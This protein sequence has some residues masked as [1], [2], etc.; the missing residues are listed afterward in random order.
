VLAEKLSLWEARLN[1]HYRTLCMASLLGHEATVTGMPVIGGCR[2]VCT[3]DGREDI[4]FDETNERK[5]IRCLR[6][7]RFPEAEAL[8]AAQWQEVSRQLSDP[9]WFRKSLAT[10]YIIIPKVTS[11]R[12]VANSVDSLLLNANL[13]TELL[14]WFMTSLALPGFE[15]DAIVERWAQKRTPLLRDWAPYAFFCIKACSFFMWLRHTT[16]LAQALQI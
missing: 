14:R 4:L 6:E 3:Q 15:Q 12:K 1:V 9:S 11:L 5:A 7:Y 10:H 2:V 13:Q 8:L 16:F